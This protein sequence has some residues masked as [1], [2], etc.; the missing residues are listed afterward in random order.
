MERDGEKVKVTTEEARGGSTP[1]IL[2]YM[3]FA[4]LTLAIVLLSA[5]WITGALTN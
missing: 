5:V 4:G 2:R 1:N 3:L